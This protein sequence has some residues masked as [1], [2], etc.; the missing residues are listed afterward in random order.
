VEAIGAGLRQ[1]YAL[2]IDVL[3][4]VDAGPGIAASPAIARRQSPG[5]RRGDRGRR[6][7][8]D[9]LSGVPGI[10]PGLF[11]HVFDLIEPCALRIVPWC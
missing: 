5:G 11:K 2:G 4:L 9:R 3:D 6:R 1:R 7:P 8:R 10:Y